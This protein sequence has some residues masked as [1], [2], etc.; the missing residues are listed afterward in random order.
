[1]RAAAIQG[2]S[3]D[4]PRQEGSVPRLR[5][6]APGSDCDHSKLCTNANGSRFKAL[7]ASIREARR[8]RRRRSV[9]SSGLGATAPHVVLEPDT[10][11]ERLAAWTPHP[12]VSSSAISGGPRRFVVM[13]GAARSDVIARRMPVDVEATRLNRSTLDLPRAHGTDQK[14][15]G[16]RRDRR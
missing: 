13:L 15:V 9:P 1:M 11:L 3:A 10:L 16:S 2:V 7:C 14:N 8:D 5:Q 6:D 12:F 4:G